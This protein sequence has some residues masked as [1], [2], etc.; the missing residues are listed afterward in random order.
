MR[1]QLQRI[2]D[3]AS[4]E[5]SE[6]R[7]RFLRY[8][9]EEMLAGRADRLKGYSIATAVFERDDSFDPQTDPVVRLEAGR[10]RRALEHYYLTAGRNDPMRIEIPK[11]SY[12]PICER[13]AALP[14]MSGV[15][16]ASTSSPPLAQL[17]P[18]ARARNRSALLPA[19]GPAVVFGAALAL[20]GAA[21]GFWLARPPLD[22]SIAPQQRVG[23][24]PAVIVLP[25][26]NLSESAADHRFAAGL[27]EELIADLTRFEDLRVYAADDDLPEQGLPDLAARDQRPD[28]RYVVKGSVRRAANGIRTTVHLIDT[29]SGRYLWSESYDRSPGGDGSVALQTSLG[30]ELA[31]RLAEPHGIIRQVTAG[32]QGK[33]RPEIL[34]TYD[35]ISQA[36]SYRRTFSRDLYL[37]T[38]DCLDEAVRHDPSRPDAWAMLAFAHLDEFRWY[39]FGPRHRQP[40]ALDQALAAARRA[41]ELDRDSSLS[42]SAYAAVKFYRGELDEAEAAQRR[43]LTLNPNNPEL[44]AQLGWRV[45]FTRDWDEGIAMVGQAIER[46]G[47]TDGWYFLL[48]AFDDYRHGDCG[49]AL[50]GVARIGGTFFF[51]S[52]ALVAMCQADLGDQEAARQALEEAVARDPTFAEDPRGAFRLHR[53]PEDLIDR[54]MDGLRKAGLNTSPGPT[55]TTSGQ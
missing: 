39:G 50:A 5:A 54:F 31:T 33:D 19:A 43:A 2:L 44:L 36:Y 29:G 48:L 45:A 52:P 27:T 34:R 9:V 41:T 53:T 51:L 4:F 11:G 25:F 1:A 38:R 42:L 55:L 49:N 35:C 37:S 47:A 28:V 15:A 46:S 40:E 18:P 21:A 22:Q 16:T 3:S 32:L 10:L 8:V 13:Q 23:E 30:A 20:A 17:V 6:R 24:E 14:E 7:R 12:V 26:A